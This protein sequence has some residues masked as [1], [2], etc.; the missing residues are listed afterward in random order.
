MSYNIEDDLHDN[1]NSYEQLRMDGLQHFFRIVPTNR[2]Q[3]DEGSYSHVDYAQWLQYLSTPITNLLKSRLLSN[4]GNRNYATHYG[5]KFQVGIYIIF[6]KEYGVAVHHGEGDREGREVDL[7]LKSRASIIQSPD[8]IEVEVDNQIAGL[9]NRIAEDQIRGSGLIFKRIDYINID[10]AYF[11]LNLNSN[12]GSYIKSPDALS[13]K[14]CC[15]NP[16]NED[17]DCF[18]W[19]LVLF[20]FH[21]QV[22]DNPERILKYERFKNEITGLNLNFTNI[23]R[24]NSLSVGDIR[25]FE[26]QN[27][28]YEI[29]LYFWNEDA[30]KTYEV[31]NL[32]LSPFNNKEPKRKFQVNLLMLFNKET[33]NSHY[34]WIKNYPKLCSNVRIF[35]NTKHRFACMFC[36]HSFLNQTQLDSHNTICRKDA[37]E[38]ISKFPKYGEDK[39]EFKEYYKKLPTPYFIVADMESINLPVAARVKCT[40]KE[41]K[42]TLYFTPS[43]LEKP[44]K[45]GEK[46][47]CSYCKEDLPPLIYA[48]EDECEY[49]FFD[50]MY[51]EQIAEEEKPLKTKVLNEQR[52]N[53]AGFYKVC[54]FDYTKNSRIEIVK[55]E[56]DRELLREDKYSFGVKFMRRIIDVANECIESVK[57]IN[58]PMNLTSEEEKEFQKS[59]IC[60]ICE[61]KFK[62]AQERVRD[63]DHLTGKFRGAAHSDCNL[64]FN[65]GVDDRYEELKRDEDE[66]EDLLVNDRPK[67][68]FK[69]YRKKPIKWKVPVFFHNLKNYDGHFIVQW[70]HDLGL[71]QIRIIPLNTEKF[72]S[73][74]VGPI[75]FLDSYAFFTSSLDNLI[76]VLM[77]KQ[78]GLIKELEVINEALVKC[79]EPLI[80]KSSTLEAELWKRKEEIQKIIKTNEQNGMK[81]FKFLQQEF[82]RDFGIIVD[83]DKQEEALQ[84]C[85]KKGHWLYEYINSI[86][87]LNETK[88]PPPECYASQLT[89]SKGLNEHEYKSEKKKWELFKMYRLWDLH[90]LYLKLDIVLLADVLE[91]C[92]LEFIKSYGLDYTW[93]YTLPGFAWSALRKSGFTNDKGETEK[94]KLKLFNEDPIERDMLLWIE[95][96]IRGGMTV[97]SK[98]YVKADNPYVNKENESKNSNQLNTYLW[99]VDANQLY[100]WAMTQYLPYDN[101]YWVKQEEITKMTIEQWKENII[102]M[103]EDSNQGC[104]F[105]VDLDYPIE[106]HDLH[107]DYPLAPENREVGLEELSPM[108]LYLKEKNQLHYT[109]TAKLCGTLN[110]K[111]NY[112]V[113]YRTLKLYLELGMELKKIHKIL[114]FNQKPWMK[115]FVLKNVDFRQKANSDFLKD[116]YKLL[117]NAVFGKT[118]ENVRK[119]CNYELLNERKDTITFQ[120]RVMHPRYK[121]SV[122][123]AHNTQLLGVMSYKPSVLFNKPILTGFSVLDLSKTLM[124]NFYYNGMKKAYGQNV[125]LCMT[126]TDSLVMEIKTMDLYKDLINKPELNSF[127]DFSNYKNFINLDKLSIIPTNHFNIYKDFYS[128]YQGEAIVLKDNLVILPKERSSFIYA[129]DPPNALLEGFKKEN[130]KVQGKF[131][132]ENGGIPLLEF[133]GLKPKCYAMLDVLEH[134][135]KKAKGVP[136]LALKKFHKMEHFKSCIELEQMKVHDIDFFKLASQKHSMFFVKSSKLSLSGFDTKRWV[137]DDNVCSLPFGHKDIQLLREQSQWNKA[138]EEKEE[139]GTSYQN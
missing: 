130:N 119:R 81:N 83:N 101:F 79:S 103:A 48:K 122:L 66:P 72:V 27:Q 109:K 112:K 63:H 102:N 110:H 71:E 37:T 13:N 107:K 65:Y 76:N 131:K 125:N 115:T 94:I 127:I 53:A 14:K 35:S 67:K 24:E 100:A 33:T 95:K 32:S 28:D 46:R 25:Q 134:E 38:A 74:E 118:M 16:K 31:E 90:D 80:E 36:S 77:G 85:L 4:D 20:H 21:N 52:A 93:D 18:Y 114:G 99:Y 91:N 11:E 98:R 138:L 75:R 128:Q 124:F 104:I 51:D 29:N 113:H 57:N 123:I 43:M 58:I 1:F 84:L 137:M 70:L 40:N 139:K 2:L 10:F 108:M 78:E 44:M 73:I 59:E 55:A 133:C 47:L 135:T 60:H 39:L 41:C 23:N 117:N 3:D 56:S 62:T 19:C 22:T 105:E 15:I 136:K 12:A 17:N 26:L 50:P 87:R 9:I 82:K 132:D 97:V 86:K 7:H 121:E 68:K 49:T 92:R 42:M 61:E 88:I 129:N 126:D 5:M 64:N 89:Y 30:K 106:L 8:V 111:K 120:R 6:E 45:E 34:I 116:L 54:T 69:Q 96:E